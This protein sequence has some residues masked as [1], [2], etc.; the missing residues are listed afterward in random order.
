LTFTLVIFALTIQHW[1]LF[2]AFWNKAGAN[3]YDLSQKGWSSAYGLV[4]L[5]N[6]QVDRQVNSNLPSGAFVDGIA[7]AISLAVAFNP[8]VGRIGLL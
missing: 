1:Y 3:D 4:S 2:R 7:C 8:V 5:S 6:D